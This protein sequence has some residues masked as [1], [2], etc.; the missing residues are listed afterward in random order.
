M[1]RQPTN[2]S[3]PSAAGG[4]TGAAG[5][6]GGGLGLDGVPTGLTPVG[7]GLT[8]NM[9]GIR[10]GSTV[11]VSL[12]GVNTGAGITHATLTA[13]EQE[14]ARTAKIARISAML[15]PRLGWVSQSGVERAA[16]RAKLEYMWE[17]DA[18]TA[19]GSVD[20][21]Q[22]RTLSIAGNGVLVEIQFK[23]D[24][25]ED[26]SLSY[27]EH[28]AGVGGF[29]MRGAAVLKRE[30]QG[31]N[32]KEG[33]IGLQGFMK[34][35]E[36]LATMDR[37][38]TK[39]VS[40]FDAI[41]GIRSA[42]G[43]LWSYEVKQVQERSHSQGMELQEAEREVLCRGSG[44]PRMHVGRR[45]GLSLQYWMVR[46]KIPSE[47]R[48]E[49]P[50]VMDVD[51]EKD[52]EVESDDREEVVSLLIECEAS[53]AD[54]YP[55]VRVSSDW[56]SAAILAPSMIKV[57]PE[58]EPSSSLPLPL[59]WQEPP[60]THLKH[61]AT[62]GNTA[63]DPMH[64][65]PSI[66]AQPSMRFIAKLSTPLIVPLY[67]AMQLL[68]TLNVSLTQEDLTQ[69]QN[70]YEALL[71]SDLLPA[72]KLPTDQFLKVLSV[73]GRNG[74]VTNQRHGYT[75]FPLQPVLGYRLAGLPFS[76]LRQIVDILPVLRQWALV[77]Q[78]L[79]RL[80]AVTATKEDSVEVENGQQAGFQR[81]NGFDDNQN[82]EFDDGSDGDSDE[83]FD[84]L[85]DELAAMLVPSEPKNYNRSGKGSTAKTQDSC[86]NAFSPLPIDISLS[87]PATGPPNFQVMYPS[88]D[89]K[90]EMRYFTFEIASNG[91]INVTNVSLGESTTRKEA[92]RRPEPAETQGRRER[93]RQ[94][95]KTISEISEDIGTTVAFLRS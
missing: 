7:M 32:N 25:V 26:V 36:A 24:M 5:M 70:T 58:S 85:D 95:I 4:M 41:D 14:A 55:P 65:S 42:L 3:S 38:S 57:S 12:N 31:T 75:L 28:G 10:R 16:K 39:G 66:P 47:R 22:Q 87:L 18:Q 51:D 35:L 37:L 88:E 86:K 17:D 68:A 52:M 53:S 63:D 29:A 33:F 50:D 61:S 59:D 44:R 6:I 92:I 76:H 21:S 74:E 20:P 13:Q 11:A 69:S 81:Q 23:G 2:T 80:Y 62:N 94:L 1:S 73:H 84:T 30:L 49:I 27:P 91:I 89:G 93:E 8:P 40:A 67:V 64:T 34:N 60:P 9:P 54:L 19:T 77:A 71:L 78:L 46:Q 82:S 15:E 45:V 90:P 43:K 72:G 79:R 56:I 48:G 83:A